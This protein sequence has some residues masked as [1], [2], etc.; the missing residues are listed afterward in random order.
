VRHD[1]D[2]PATPTAMVPGGQGVP[3]AVWDRG[4]GRPLV[5]VH[6]VLADHRRFAELTNLLVSS[7]RVFAVDRRG[8]GASGDGAGYDVTDEF[9]D[10]AAVCDWVAARCG[11]EPALWGHSFGADVALGAATRTDRISHLVLYEPGLDTTCPAGSLETITERLAD[12][13]LEAAVATFILEVMGLGSDMLDAMRDGPTWPMRLD[14]APALARELRAEQD[15]T[16]PDTW[17]QRRWPPTLFLAGSE[18]PPEQQHA[19]AAARRVVAGSTVTVLS[20]HA[21]LAF[22]DDPGLV[23]GLLADFVAGRPAPAATAGR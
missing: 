8:R 2:A 14:A 1:D 15:W 12:G 21:H 18:S 7:F 13:D 19:T 23:A 5:L 4:V 10:I 20:G 17:Q 9:D 11:T 6:G 22:N 16:Y 3:I